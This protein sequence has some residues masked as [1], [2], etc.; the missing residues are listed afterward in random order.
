MQIRSTNSQLQSVFSTGGNG[1]RRLEGV[2]DDVLVV[3]DSLSEDAVLQIMT[4]RR[5]VIAEDGDL[6]SESVPPNAG[7]DFLE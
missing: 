4:D 2:L 1:D 7:S 5:G 6:V 3:G